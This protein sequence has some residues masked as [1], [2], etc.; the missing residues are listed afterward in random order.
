M[1]LMGLEQLPEARKLPLKSGLDN[2][3]GEKLRAKS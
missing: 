2:M 1:R 3:D